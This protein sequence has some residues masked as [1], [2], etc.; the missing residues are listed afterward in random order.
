MSTAVIPEAIAQLQRQLDQI[1][2]TQPRGRKLPDSV[3]Q[4][5][6]ELARE[7]GVYSVAHPLRLDYTGLK[8]R[9]GGVSH[10]RRK[11]REP[12]FVELIAPSSPSKRGALAAV[13]LG[14]VNLA[15]SL[16]QYQFASHMSFARQP[17]PTKTAIA[18]SASD[19]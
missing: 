10:G 14:F 6:V 15:V 17:K 3:W 18:S 1:R 9:L 19:V 12:T 7:H 2:S 4:A 5:A 11:A 8:K 13:C 16:P